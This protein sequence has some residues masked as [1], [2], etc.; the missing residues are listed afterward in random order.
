[1]R[2]I[3]DEPHPTRST[4]SSPG[5][6]ARRTTSRRFQFLCRQLSRLGGQKRGVFWRQVGAKCSTDLG[7]QGG[8]SKVYIT[9]CIE[10]AKNAVIIDFHSRLR[11]KSRRRAL[12]TQAGLAAC[13]WARMRQSS[14]GLGSHSP[15]GHS[16]R[17]QGTRVPDG[18][19][20]ARGRASPNEDIR[21]NTVKTSI[22]ISRDVPEN[23]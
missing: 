20:S 17:Q 10:R 21:S 7:T 8:Q 2:R 18:S 11:N 6:C 14:N 1:M 4:C 23:R 13:H 5:G 15:P 9:A 12:S 22:E 3:P 16:C 19:S